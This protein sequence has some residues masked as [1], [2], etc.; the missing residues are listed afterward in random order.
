MVTAIRAPSGKGAGVAV[1]EAVVV[2]V[3]VSPLM[4]GE[5]AR[6]GGGRV[7]WATAVGVIVTVVTAAAGSPSLVARCEFLTIE[8]GVMVAL[9]V[10][11]QPIR[12]MNRPRKKNR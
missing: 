5:A 1:P 10:L 11:W 6:E 7:A 2:G 3:G 4:V 12:Q 9:S 8:T